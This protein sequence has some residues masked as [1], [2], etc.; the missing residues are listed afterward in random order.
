MFE[1]DDRLYTEAEKTV[2]G[3]V[4]VTGNTTLL[5]LAST[6]FPPASITETAKAAVLPCT[7]GLVTPDTVTFP[8]VVTL[9]LTLIMTLLVLRW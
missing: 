1:V 8:T 5:M 4:P 2:N 6:V 9:A 3:P 7:L